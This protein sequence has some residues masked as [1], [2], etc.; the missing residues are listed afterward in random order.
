VTELLSGKLKVTLS[1]AAEVKAGEI[2]LREIASLEGDSSLVARARSISVGSSPLAGGSRQLSRSQIV[3][4][5]RAAQLLPAQF[6]LNMAEMVT[7]TRPAQDIP[8]DALIDAARGALDDGG[9]L[10]VVPG[11]RYV[12]VPLGEYDVKAGRPMRSGLGW[13]V[14]VSVTIDGALAAT[15]TVRFTPAR[16]GSGDIA[17]GGVSPGDQVTVRIESG[18]LVIETAGVVRQKGTVGGEVSVYVP[19]TH[20]TVRAEVLDSST[21]KVTQ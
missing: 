5:L 15:V 11:V 8:V 14:P 19:S 10:D 17:Q 3:T 12:R 18:T 1:P 6:D 21:V 4:K 20:K 13:A 16:G 9:K 7:V 2:L